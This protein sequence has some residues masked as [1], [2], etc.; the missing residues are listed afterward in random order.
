MI[1][2]NNIM[3]LVRISIVLVLLFLIIY[4][5]YKFH[6][7]G[8]LKIIYNKIDETL[9]EKNDSER[10]SMARLQYFITVMLSNTVFWSIIIFGSIL[11]GEIINIPEVL[12]FV[13]LSINGISGAVKVWQ[14]RYETNHTRA[15]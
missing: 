1:M 11:K 15:N 2:H 5:I 9:K 7:L 6:K 3:L 13:Y 12:A 4:A 10:W 14:K 8:Y